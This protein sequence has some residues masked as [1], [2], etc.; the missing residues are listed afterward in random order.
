[1]PIEKTKN[2][3]KCNKYDP[4]E[5]IILNEEETNKFLEILKKRKENDFVA[6]LKNKYNEKKHSTEKKYVL[7]S[8]RLGILD[9]S[10]DNDEI[11]KK[12]IQYPDSIVLFTKK[13]NI[14]DYILLYK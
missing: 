14:S 6:Q 1:M 5:N 2:I 12:K 4:I 8:D 7:F 9:E 10:D 3:E 13:L 11:E